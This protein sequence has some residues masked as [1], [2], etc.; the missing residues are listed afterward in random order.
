MLLT[1]MKGKLHRATVTQ[2][3]LH[4]EGSITVDQDLLD[5]AGILVHE[6]VD[7][8]DIDNGNRLT[9]YTIPGERG[10]GVIGINGAAARL[11]SPGDKVIIIAYVQM[12]EQ[13]A[14]AH[15]P[16][17]VLLDDDNHPVTINHQSGAAFPS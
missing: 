17:V 11:V 8:L 6:Q 14:K 4:Y 3:D 5:A 9:T 12:D 2:A 1:M 15:E 13:A 16:N 7:V 10:S